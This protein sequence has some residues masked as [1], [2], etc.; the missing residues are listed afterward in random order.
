M[1]STMEARLLNALQTEFPLV[2]R[3]FAE[4]GRRLGM[5][6]AEII[7]SISRAKADGIIRQIGPVMDG[8]RLGFHSTLAA[9]KVSSENLQHTEVVIAAHPGV[10]HGYERENT[11]NIWFTLSVGPT[12]D[13]DA[14]IASLKAATGSEVAFSLPVVRMFKLGAYFDME[15]D[16][17]APPV[18]MSG[19]LGVVTLTAQ[20]RLV[21]N[22]LQQDLPLTREPFVEMAQRTGMTV[23]DFLSTCRALLEFGAVRRFSASINPRRAGFSANAMTCWAVPPELTASFGERLAAIRQVSHCYERATNALWRRN[24]FAMVHGHNT[25]ECEDVAD[26]ISAETGLTDRLFLY[27]THEFKKARVI[28]RI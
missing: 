28:Y 11:F 26:R 2:P 7:G 8:R 6:E 12:Q 22:E 24:I 21:L 9:M 1:I 15:G 10:S 19:H 27:S 13:I 4:L 14:E 18:A 25:Q 20:Q 16:G 17:L 5:T 3:P 23:A